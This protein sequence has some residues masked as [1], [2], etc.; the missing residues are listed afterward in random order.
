MMSA[1][2]KK[3]LLLLAV[4][5]V[6]SG[7]GSTPASRFYLLIPD[8]QPAATPVL[9]GQPHIG[10][11]P[12]DLPKYLDRPQIVTRSDSAEIRLTETE[13]WAEPLQENFTRVLAENL[14]RRL[15]TGRVSIEP[16]HNR[17]N[18]DYRVIADVLQFDAND[19]GEIMLLVY[20]NILDRNGASLTGMQK[21]EIR[22]PIAQPAD[23]SRTVSRLSAAVAELGRTIAARLSELPAVTTGNTTP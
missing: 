4:P 20:W 14:S 9:A 3:L 13:R 23:T 22:M 2:Y 5:V 1:V 15:G 16:S 21:S 8:E 7:C 12:I 11:G 19:A 10:V 18:I 6:L 17:G